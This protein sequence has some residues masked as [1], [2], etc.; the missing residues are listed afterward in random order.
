MYTTNAT[1]IAIPRTIDELRA[2]PPDEL[3]GLLDD[4]ETSPT[5]LLLALPPRDEWFDSGAE[6]QEEWL[7]A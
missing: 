7:T 6:L 5:V 1:Y 3:Y 2:L 4:P